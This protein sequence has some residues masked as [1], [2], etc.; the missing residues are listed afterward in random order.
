MKLFDRQI[1]ITKLYE[2][3]MI[4]YDSWND[5]ISNGKG[6]YIARLYFTEPIDISRYKL[7]DP[8]SNDH[9]QIHELAAKSIG[10]ITYKLISGQIGLFYI[11]RDKYKNR[12]LG[13]QI[14]S[15]VIL[16]MKEEGRDNIFAVTSKDNK[17]WSNVFDGSFQWKDRP[18]NTV[19]GS[20]YYMKI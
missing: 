18:S 8:T 19:T 17:F 4:R 12:K 1:D 11:N 2:V 9:N 15:K 10:Y 16:D 6:K 14:L 7:D 13:K 5:K 3:K 20:G